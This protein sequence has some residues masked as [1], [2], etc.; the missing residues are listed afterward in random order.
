MS[1]YAGD[2]P[3]VVQPWFLRKKTWIIAAVVFGF[4]AI[5]FFIFTYIGLKK[6][7]DVGGGVTIEADP[8]TKIY[9]GENWVGT[10][11][12]SFTW[13]ELF[14]D[15]RQNAM[16]EE[17]SNSTNSVTPE[18]VSGPGAVVLDSQ[19][20]SG[21][22]TGAGGLMVTVSGFRYLIRRSDG[23]LDQV[24]G[25]VIDW[26]PA[27][28]RSRRFLLPVRLR[29]GEKDSTVFFNQ[30]GSSSSASG[31]GPGFVKIFGQSPTVVNKTFRF[32]AN[33]PPFQ[34]AE[35]IKKKG[36]WEPGAK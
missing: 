17:L 18:Q 35:E 27:N 31:G 24:A 19:P 33:P 4:L 26:A 5:G 14:G 22:G 20:L 32:S 10:T 2:D 9:V 25:I 29:K 6:V 21:G 12:V 7:P 16:A 23:D 1:Y 28:E 15:K 36:L 30:S 13:D 11:Q 34:L 3:D 8:D